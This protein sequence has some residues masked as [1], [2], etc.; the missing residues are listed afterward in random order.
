L[1]YILV[2]LDFYCSQTAPRAIKK[3]AAAAAHYPRRPVV[4]ALIKQKRDA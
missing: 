1:L 4:K 3:R 2:F